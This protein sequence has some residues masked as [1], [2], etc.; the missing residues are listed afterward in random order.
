LRINEQIRAA[1][2]RVIDADGKQLGIYPFREALRL[3]QER[4]VDLVEVAPEAKPPV[5]RLM[6]YGK[7]LYSRTKREREARKSQRRTEVKEIQFRPKT[8]EHDIRFKIKRIRKFLN[9]GAKVK[10][11]IRFRSRESW[12]PEIARDLLMRVADEVAD[13]SSIEQMPSMEGRAMLMLLNAKH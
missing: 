9:E 11:K 3:A 10:V 5:C 4:E 13:I 6:D 7:Y 1:E 2:L 8:A 12:Y